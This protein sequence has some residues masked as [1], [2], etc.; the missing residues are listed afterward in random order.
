MTLSLLTR[1]PE[2][3]YKSHCKTAC[4]HGTSMIAG[5]AN[6]EMWAS[7]PTGDVKTDRRRKQ[8]E[9][10]SHMSM[11]KTVKILLLERNMTMTV[12]A[13]KLGKSIQNISSKLR[14][15]NLS[16]KELHDIARACDAAFVGG[17]VLNDTGKEIK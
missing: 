5:R 4:R 13:N 6:S 7:R 12:L 8:T 11:A 1:I 9:R 14:R 3:P 15:D 2:K 17:F 10:D 16:E